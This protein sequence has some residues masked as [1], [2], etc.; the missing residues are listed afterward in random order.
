MRDKYNEGWKPFWKDQK[1][2]YFIRTYNDRLDLDDSYSANRIL[3]F[4]DSETRDRFFEDHRD[5]IEIAK[6]FL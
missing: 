5:L 3:T 1:I 2:K 4:K 6:P